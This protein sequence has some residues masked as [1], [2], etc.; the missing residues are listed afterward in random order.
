MR[1]SG[2]NSAGLMTIALLMVF[3]IGC[4]DS[5]T[6]TGAN[7]SGIDMAPDM[8]ADMAPDMGADMAPDIG[9]DMTP[10]MGADMAPDMGA[11]MGLDAP[12]ADLAV[13]DVG[14]D[15][16]V[17]VDGGSAQEGMA[18]AATIDT[19]AP[20]L[21]DVTVL[22]AQIDVTSADQQVT[23][24]IEATDATAIQ[25]IF[26]IFGKAGTSKT[27]PAMLNDQ[28][29]NPATLAYEHTFTVPQGQEPGDYELNHV[30]L[31]DTLGNKVVVDLA[32]P[33]KA[34]FDIST[35]KFEVVNTP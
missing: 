15:G 6:T 17:A 19:D 14:M 13:P 30:D 26:I 25:S 21:V 8:G 27:F 16:P 34:G 3:S 2:T 22:P 5:S 24:S 31:K 1:T 9:A 23:V 33:T 11:D 10:D 18:D 32:D 29:Y 20:V 12:V 28:S 7:D 4:D 35:V